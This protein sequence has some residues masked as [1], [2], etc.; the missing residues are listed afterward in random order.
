MAGSA[1]ARARAGNTVSFGWAREILQ[2]SRTHNTGIKRHHGV[3]DAQGQEQHVEAPPRQLLPNRCWHGYLSHGE[4]PIDGPFEVL[5][6]NSDQLRFVLSRP[7]L[8]CAPRAEAGGSRSSVGKST[9]IRVQHVKKFQN[10]LE[11][12]LPNRPPTLQF[13]T[14]AL[15]EERAVGPGLRLSRSFPS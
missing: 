10:N 2:K 1:G 5:V 3:C 6:R 7:N 8:H 14:K 9:R 11:I 4:I 13:C 12:A 15:Q